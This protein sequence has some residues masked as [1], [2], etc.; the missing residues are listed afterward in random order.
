MKQLHNLLCSEKKQLKVHI[1][2]GLGFL[3][4]LQGDSIT[5]LPRVLSR[6][7]VDVFHF[8]NNNTQISPGLSIGIKARPRTD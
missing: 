7:E 6:V 3:G 2:S 8:Q 4:R 5:P 1:C